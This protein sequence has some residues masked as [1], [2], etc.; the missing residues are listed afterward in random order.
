MNADFV[1]T[2]INTDGALLVASSGHDNNGTYA[3]HIMSVGDTKAARMVSTNE[4]IE[5]ELSVT[6]N[7]PLL[8]SD[9][10]SSKDMAQVMD[11]IQCVFAEHV[12][13]EPDTY[14][15]MYTAGIM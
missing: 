5:S 13:A 2:T 11:R 1:S 6:G 15:D 7:G 9:Y 14:S 10:A 8:V 12:E 3:A 4:Q